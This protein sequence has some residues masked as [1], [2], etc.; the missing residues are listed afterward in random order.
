VGSERTREIRRRRTR[1]KKMDLLKKKA[2]KANS[3]EK[4]AIAEKIRKLTPGAEGIIARLSLE[5]R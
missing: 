4:A 3:S 2:E 5:E 1:R